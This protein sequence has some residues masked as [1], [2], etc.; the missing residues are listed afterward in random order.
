VKTKQ[1]RVVVAL[2]AVI[3]ALLVAGCGERMVKVQ[4]GERV[5]CIYGELVSST[6]KTVEVPASKA[7]D[8]KVVTKTVTC[9]KHKAI[10]DLYA[11]AQKAIAAGDLKTARAKLAEVLGLDA[12][13]RKAAQQAAQIDAGKKPAADTGSGP[14][15]S[16]TPTAT[17]GGG[18][19]EGPVASLASWVPDTLAGYKADAVEADTVSLTRQ[20]V[21]TGSKPVASIVVVAEQYKDAATAKAAAARTI[22]SQYSTG[23]TTVT[24]KGRT[25][26]FGTLSKQFAALAWNEG[27][28]LVVIEGY[29]SSGTAA[30]LK[31]ELASVA[32]ALIK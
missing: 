29:T 21:P 4:T 30:G 7:I 2:F 28:V 27:A 20:Y 6:V 14:T 9:A 1:P 22:A 31:D 25:V 8:Y 26:L 11:A 32:A 19:P 24:V 17:P 3:M 5:V 12:T 10:E 13:Y 18:I 15:G 16:T 23:R